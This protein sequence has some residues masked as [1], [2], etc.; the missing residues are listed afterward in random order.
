MQSSVREANVIRFIRSY[1]NMPSIGDFYSMMYQLELSELIESRCSIAE[2]TDIK[3]RSY[4]LTQGTHR[5]MDTVLS[6][7]SRIAFG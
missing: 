5:K 2:G 4:R 7:P 1:W 3:I 6:M